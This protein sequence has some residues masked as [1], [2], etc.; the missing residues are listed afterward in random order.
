MTP[1]ESA[2]KI[3]YRFNSE[4]DIQQPYDHKIHMVR[5]K[6]SAVICIEEILKVVTTIEVE[7]IY[8]EEALEVAKNLDKKYI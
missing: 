6:D 1:E 8:W 2:K 7:K 3:F 4:T 5:A